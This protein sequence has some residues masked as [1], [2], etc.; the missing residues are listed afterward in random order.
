MPGWRASVA[1]AAVATTVAC[2]HPAPTAPSAAGPAGLAPVTV[3]VPAGMGQAPLDTPRRALVPRNWT[4]SVWARVPSAR[5]AIWAPD[6]ALLVSVPASGQVL[7]LTPDGQQARTTVL[8]DGLRQP[9]GLAFD[10]PTLYV[11]ESDQINTFHYANGAATGRRVIAAGLPDARSPELGGAYAHALKSVAVAPDA[12][13]YFSI[14]S[15]GNISAA[16][17]TANPPRAT[18]MRIPPGGGAPAL[19]ATGV[20]NGT[21]LAV[22]PDGSVW[23]AVNNRDDVADPRPGPAYG[24]VTDYVNDHPPEFIARL[25]AGRELGWPYCNPEADGFVRDV[26]TNAGGSALDCAALPAVEQ[27]LGAHSA[28]LGLSFVDGSLPEPFARGAL[29]GVH[30]SWNRTPPRAPEVSFFAWRNGT[31]GPQ[32]TLVGGF[33]AEDGTRWGRPVAAVAGPDGAVYVTDDY[34][35]AVYRLAPPGR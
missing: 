21:G 35:G 23:T 13:V 31:L 29:L 14:G 11:A 6:G 4:M 19:F 26:Q 3:T 15:T 34:A 33:Q 5:L 28:P 32:Q 1:C 18:I 7:R 27:T 22:A 8:L 2:G 24:K 10:G 20:R 17:R 25:A 9:H 16:D 30:G 12:A